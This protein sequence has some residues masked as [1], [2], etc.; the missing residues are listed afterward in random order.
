M[1]YFTHLVEIQNLAFAIFLGFT[2]VSFFA[3]IFLAG[4]GH[5]GHYD[6]TNPYPPIESYGNWVREGQGPVPLFLKLWIVAIASFALALTG[7]VIY[8]GYRY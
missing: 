8:H 5:H 1:G 2:L 4:R 3:L 6:G 7:I